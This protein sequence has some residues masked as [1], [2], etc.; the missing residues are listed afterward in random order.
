PA[1]PARPD[2]PPG[3]RSR[4][5]HVRRTP[6]AGGS[7]RPAPVCRDRSARHPAGEPP[8]PGRAGRR[9][10]KRLAALLTALLLG[11]GSAESWCVA[12]W[13]PSSDHAGGS[14]A[15]EVNLDVIE[16]VYAFWLT[17]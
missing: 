2:R 16:L 10:M 13:Y 6:A 4:H 9:N 12:V 11:A 1:Q 15:I 7:R 5:L 17:P 3:R 14:A 8:A